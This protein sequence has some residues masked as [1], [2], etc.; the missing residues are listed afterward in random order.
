MHLN[1]HDFSSLTSVGELEFRKKY[2]EIAVPKKTDSRA[3]TV[4]Q[5]VFNDI[6]GLFE[7]HRR[8]QSAGCGQ[9]ML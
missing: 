6:H 1:Q 3:S 5:M 7:L 9:V 4:G 8:L 2:T